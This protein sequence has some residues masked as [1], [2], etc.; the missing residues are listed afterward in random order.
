MSKL[1]FSR[2]CLLAAALGLAGCGGLAPS[3]FASD[4]PRFEPEKFFS[5]HV[6]S[7]GVVESRSGDPSRRFTTDIRGRAEGLDLVMDQRFAFDDGR[8]E[9]RVWHLHRVDAHRYEATAGDVVGTAVGESYGNAFRFE[10][11]LALDPGN[12]LK[13]VQMKQWMYAVG[14]GST[15]MNRVEVTKFGVT[16][17]QVTEFFT[18]QPN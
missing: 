14:D 15:M 1:T 5:G 6:Q 2:W 3:D 16:V 12:P 11:T 8:T 7:W 10:Y 4:Q 17:A 13:N 18:K 9:R